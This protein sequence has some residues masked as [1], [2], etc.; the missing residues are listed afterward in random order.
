MTVG[1]TDKDEETE[2]CS[3]SKS[4]SLGYRKLQAERE[5]IICRRRAGGGS[6]AWLCSLQRTST[7]TKFLF[8][9]Q[10]DDED[11]DLEPKVKPDFC[12]LFLTHGAIMW[13]CITDFF[14]YETTKSVVVKSW[15]IGIINRIVQLLIITYFIGWV[16]LSRS[17]RNIT[18]GAASSVEMGKVYRMSVPFSGF[19]WQNLCVEVQTVM[20]TYRCKNCFVYNCEAFV[21]LIF[22]H[23]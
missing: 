23:G 13:S 6:G 7:V 22:T 4:W 9:S 5:N 12:S 3:S 17:V 19:K 18:T 10:S 11:V 2:G 20:S 14:T 1:W 21:L 16:P 15:T 8:S